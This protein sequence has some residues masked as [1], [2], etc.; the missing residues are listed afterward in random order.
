MK[1]KDDSYCQCSSLDLL[2]LDKR[3]IAVYLGLKSLGY[4][5][6]KLSSKVPAVNLLR[7]ALY[8]ISNDIVEGKTGGS[9][10]LVGFRHGQEGQ[11]ALDFIKE[12]T[13]CEGE[14]PVGSS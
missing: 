8:V 13:V 9:D 5:K 4:E 6:T 3:N 12:E 7:G 1:K 14:S 10:L 2:S 11:L